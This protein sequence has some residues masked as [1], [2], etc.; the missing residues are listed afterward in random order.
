MTESLDEIAERQI[1]ENVLRKLY[2]KVTEIE[3][4]FIRFQKSD[5]EVVKEIRQSIRKMVEGLEGE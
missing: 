1:N 2:D 3:E 5:A 4:E